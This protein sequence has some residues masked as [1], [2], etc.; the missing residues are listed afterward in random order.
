MRIDVPILIADSGLFG[1]VVSFAIPHSRSL[2][3]GNIFK[4]RQEKKVP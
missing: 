1:V 3:L 4:S 2:L